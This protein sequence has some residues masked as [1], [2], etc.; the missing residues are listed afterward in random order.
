MSF[1]SLSSR[2]PPSDSSMG[3]FVWDNKRDAPR[4]EQ[5][6]EVY[7]KTAM[8]DSVLM[9]QDE[10]CC[11]KF[12]FVLCGTAGGD[13]AEATAVVDPRGGK[14]RRALVATDNLSLSICNS[15]PVP[16]CL[17]A[18]LEHPSAGKDKQ[19]D[20]V[21]LPGFPDDPVQVSGAPKGVL[22]P[23]HERCRLDIA[24][25]GGHEELVQYLAA[26]LPSARI[27]TLTKPRA[28]VF[29]VVVD[30]SNTV[31]VEIKPNH[32]QTTRDAYFFILASETADW[33]KYIQ[34]HRVP[35]YDVI[36]GPYDESGV[37]K[38]IKGSDAAALEEQRYAHKRV[39]LGA[40]Q[41]MPDVPTLY[42]RIKLVATPLACGVKGL[43]DMPV[44]TTVVMSYK[45]KL[46][47]VTGDK[48][49]A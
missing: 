18:F 41:Y 28:G 36:S 22:V 1:S 46:V 29:K 13:A 10:D 37:W 2:A 5:V 48:G 20:S 30:D 42:G 14:A 15:G 35:L 32:T 39:F 38:A 34:E 23:P 33:I 6:G 21:P 27:T 25:G 43:G 31:E 19:K 44:Y 47:N 45:G 16:V 3:G 49:N 17:S 9:H 40:K 24:I 7:D 4:G 11:G 26:D 8:T 12:Q